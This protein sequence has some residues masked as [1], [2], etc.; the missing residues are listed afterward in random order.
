MT[1]VARKNLVLFVFFLLSTSCTMNYS[2]DDMNAKSPAG[3]I[4]NN[5]EFSNKI[6]IDTTELT[7]VV[8]SHFFGP[9]KSHLIG[10]PNSGFYLG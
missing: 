3:P 6:Y 1:K 9:G 2:I 7:L 8:Q 4:N 10:P 5:V